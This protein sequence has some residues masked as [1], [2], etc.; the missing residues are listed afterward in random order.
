MASC[1]LS[2]VLNSSCRPTGTLQKRRKTSLNSA[3]ASCIFI[4]SETTER[5]LLLW[6]EEGA[7]FW[8]SKRPTKALTKQHIQE[9]DWRAPGSEPRTGSILLTSRNLC[10]SVGK[11]EGR[12]QAFIPFHWSSPEALGVCNCDHMGLK[13]GNLLWSRFKPQRHSKFGDLWGDR[14]RTGSGGR[15]LFSLVPY[16]MQ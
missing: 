14:A 16:P 10:I 15:T 12:S 9:V 4:R 1:N 2:L 7:I 6:E 3:E 11:Q 8:H 5:E 13:K